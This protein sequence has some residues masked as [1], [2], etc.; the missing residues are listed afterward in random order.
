MPARIYSPAKTAMQSGQT[1]T[2]H[3]VLEF[4]AEAPRK[5]E[6][7]MGYTSSSDMRSQVK[8][9]FESKEAAIAYAEKEGIAFTVSEPK[10]AKRRQMSY[11]DNFNYHR[12]VPW[13]H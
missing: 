9:T 8:M 13:T 4:E 7:L 3:W 1:K 12:N 11:S 5:I 2:G 10:K 6:P